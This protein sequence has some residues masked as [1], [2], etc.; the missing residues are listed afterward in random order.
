MPSRT[1]KRKL[2]FV[3]SNDYGELSTALDFIAGQPFETL[4]LA[5]DRLFRANG[6]DLPAGCRNYHSVADVLSAARAQSPEL[7]FLFSAYL[8]A[9]N[10]L[11][12]LDDVQRLIEGLRAV[13]RMIVT[14]DPFLGL[15]FHIDDRTFSDQHPAKREL[16]EHFAQVARML[17][18][19][20]HLYRVEPREGAKAGSVS[21]YNPHVVLDDAA[22]ATRT[23]RALKTLGVIR[24]LKRWLFVLSAEDY[25]AGV[26]R[27]GKN[28]FDALLASKLKETAGAGRQPVLIGPSPCLDALRHGTS[29]PT[30]AV[31]LEFCEYLT[32]QSLL[33]EAE[34]A[35]YWNIFSDSIIARVMNRQPVF[36]FDAG[37]LVR[38]MPPF[39]EAGL[40]HFYAGNAPHFLDLD[41]TL[42]AEGLA[43]SAVDEDR[44]LERA[45]QR[46]T[47]SPDPGQM[48]ELLLETTGSQ[49]SDRFSD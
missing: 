46:F 22:R 4:I 9:V 38:A 32:F 8:Y 39:F 25:G 16:T 18:G 45:R 26:A 23:A 47:Q 40:N 6:G 30:S 12:S 34:Y 19:V 3:V 11:L 17:D 28:R 13:T 44:K 20:K 7:A 36:F 37:H 15:L 27:W 42:S 35:F 14:S 41:A 10:G 21:F 24:G 49:A 43:V 5:P 48:V 33:C 2:L 29:N 31:L 1:G